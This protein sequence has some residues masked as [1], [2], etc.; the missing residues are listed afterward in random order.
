MPRQHTPI[1]WE[2]CYQDLGKLF[3]EI[4]AILEERIGAILPAAVPRMIELGNFPP[5]IAIVFPTS[6]SERVLYDP[7]Q[8]TLDTAIRAVATDYNLKVSNGVYSHRS[9]LE[10][11]MGVGRFFQDGNHFVL[12]PDYDTYKLD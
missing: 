7:L 1:D 12:K 10:M 2:K 5:H 4:N 11:R 9:K 6:D 8:L 3:P